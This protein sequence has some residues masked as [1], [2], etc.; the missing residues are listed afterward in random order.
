M[1]LKIKDFLSI[2]DLKKEELLF[3]LKTAKDFKSGKLKADSLKEKSVAMIFEKPSTRT[4][5]SF[6]TAIYELGGQPI[7]LNSTEMQLSRGETV[8]D[9]AKVISR[10]VHAITLRTF[11]HSRVVE[12][13]KHAT[14]PVINALSDFEHPCQI[15]ADLQTM[16]EKTGLQGIKAVFVG[17]GDNNVTNSFI[18]ACAILGIPLTVA[19][20]KKYSPKKAVIEKARSLSKNMGLSITDDPKA[21]VKDADVI[22]TD[23]WISMGMEKESAERKKAFMPFQV[24]S[25]LMSYAGKSNYIIMH[26]LPAHRGEEITDEIIDGPHSVVFDEAENRKHA[27]KA[28]LHL[29][30]TRNINK[31]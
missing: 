12:L 26:D 3:V 16:E 23:V 20:P 10:Y 15:L 21:A 1:N 19:C 7:N 30:M 11:E 4:R 5:L 8:H 9:T 25:K 17:D 2:T 24:N 29:L 22:Y 28:I 27:Q 6:Q 14:V 13:A 31:R 18:F